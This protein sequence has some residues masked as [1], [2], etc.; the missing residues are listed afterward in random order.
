[1]AVTSAGS[2]RSSLALI[3]VRRK[4]RR[5]VDAR[6][7]LLTLAITADPRD[8]Q[9]ENPCHTGVCDSASIR[10]LYE[11]YILI[12]GHKCSF[13]RL[14]NRTE[15]TASSNGDMATGYAVSLTYVV[16]FGHSRLKLLKG[17]A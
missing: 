13:A 9:L 16:N 1:M 12:A 15:N 11:L 17:E 8:L 2:S 7:L 4:L 3:M 14:A 10:V 6:S 5:S